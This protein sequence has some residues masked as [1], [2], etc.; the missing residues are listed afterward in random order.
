MEVMKWSKEEV[1]EWIER[2]LP[3]ESKEYNLKNL[4]FSSGISGKA[5][6]EL[7][8]SDLKEFN[9]N[10]GTRKIIMRAISKLKEGISYQIE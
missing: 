8:E 3:E 1:G 7:Q 2:E 5:L 9:L 4:F 6:I 10:L